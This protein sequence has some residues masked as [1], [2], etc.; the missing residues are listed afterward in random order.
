MDVLKVK[1]LRKSYRTGFWKR[2]TEVLKGVSFSIPKGTV[3]GFLGRNGAGKTT[4]IKCLLELAFADSGTIEFF[5]SKE[6]TSEVKNKI[7]FLHLFV[8]LR[9]P[10]FLGPG[11]SHILRMDCT[12]AGTK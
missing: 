4:T 5:G 7:G 11:S 8:L 12:Y 1:D 10:N 2:K 9:I 3:T 6:L